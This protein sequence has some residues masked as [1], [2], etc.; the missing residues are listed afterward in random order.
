VTRLAN[1][2]GASVDVWVEWRHSIDQVWPSTGIPAGVPLIVQAGGTG[3]VDPARVIHVA[4]SGGDATTVAAG[5]AL[6]QA[7]VPA[8]S[9]ANPATV[10]VYPGVYTEDPLSIPVGVTVAGCGAVATII[11][12]A[13]TTQPLVTLAAGAEINS[14]TLSGANG[15]GGVGMLANQAGTS[16]ARTM[17]ISDCTTGLRVTGANV[18]FQMLSIYILVNGGVLDTG[19]EVSAGALLDIYTSRVEGSGA[20][21]GFRATGANSTIHAFSIHAGN[22]GSGLLVE[23]SGEIEAVGGLLYD[24]SYALHTGATGGDL[25][26]YGVDVEDSGTYDLYIEAANGSFR[27]SG[28]AIRSDLLSVAAGA[29]VV[30]SHLSDYEGDRA[31]MIIG[32]LA[33]GLP[34]FPSESVFGEGDSHVR[35]M[36]ILRN[37]NLEAGVWSDITTE[38]ASAS[39]STA[40]AFPGVGIGNTLYIGG[41]EK[42]FP[43]AKINTTVAIVLGAGSLVWEYWNGAAWTAYRLMTADSVS[44]YA[45]YAEATFGRVTFD[46]V[47]FNDDDMAGWALK[48][49]NGYSRYWVRCRVAGAITTVPTLEQI[50]LHTNRTEINSD[51]V[52][53]HM[54]TGISQKQIPWHQRLT[55]DLGGA[56]PTNGALSLTT[57]ITLTPVDNRCNNNALDGFGGIFTIP[58][59]LD[60]SKDVTL[61]YNWIAKANGAAPND[62]VEWESRFGPVRIGQTLD[63]SLSDTLQTQTIT[64]GAADDDVVKQHT[65]VFD[66]ADLVPGE[67]LAFSL[68]RDATGGNLDDTFPASVDIVTVELLGW[69]W[70]D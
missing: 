14:V 5:L 40:A 37:T 18:I 61:R 12:A 65:F 20:G 46:Q 64:I 22:V 31:N 19:I 7:L 24:C 41:N 47:R 53:E 54:G 8:P 1:S 38:M 50:K 25:H 11:S 35:G 36:R 63:G 52:I 55:D 16:I 34:A 56:S 26:C 27:G 43:G 59:G 10:K 23:N 39:G 3:G 51:G 60:T 66:V 2:P 62:V 28:N 4:T 58:E 45:S 29:T 17:F 42:A 21:V 70:R 6:A 9:A 48:T 30:S 15:V 68:F 32:E 49:L 33:V 69:F 44:P 67:L 57:N 13:T